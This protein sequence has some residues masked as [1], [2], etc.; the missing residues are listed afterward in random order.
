MP[1]PICVVFS[2]KSRNNI[3]KHRFP[4]NDISRFVKWVERSGNPKLL[5]MTP[6]QIYKSYLVCDLHFDSD[7]H[8]KGTKLLKH[9]AIP[10]LCLPVCELHYRVN[11][12][13]VQCSC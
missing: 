6:E 9:N 7:C 12:I 11:H 13:Y 3:S 8:S 10:T 1:S 4:K 5:T 2:C